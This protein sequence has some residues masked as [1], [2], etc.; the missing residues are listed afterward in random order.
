M[1]LGDHQERNSVIPV[2]ITE[3]IDAGVETI[4]YQIVTLSGKLMAKVAPARQ[5]ARN[6]A[7]RGR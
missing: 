5:L 4:Y 2:E 3:A 7:F 6:A 1:T